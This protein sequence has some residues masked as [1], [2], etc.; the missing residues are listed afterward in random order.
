M[1]LFQHVQLFHPATNNEGSWLVQPRWESV[2]C[3]GCT[4]SYSKT[5]QCQF[6]CNVLHSFPQS[7]YGKTHQNY[8]WMVYLTVAHVAWYVLALAMS[9]SWYSGFLPSDL[10]RGSATQDPPWTA[11]QHH[12][13][14]LQIVGAGHFLTLSCAQLSAVHKNFLPESFR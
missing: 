14:C 4:T 1:K 10:H 7:E 6:L 2:P 9:K 5:V 11:S 8:C 12:R 3:V 13:S